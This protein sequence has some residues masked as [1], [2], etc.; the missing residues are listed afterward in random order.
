[1]TARAVDT[2]VAVLAAGQHGVV[3]RA[4][5]LAAGGT[6]RVIA[7]RLASGAWRRLAAGVYVLASHAGSWRQRLVALA[8]AAGPEAVVSHEAAAAL[9]GLD[10]YP[11]GPAVVTLSHPNHQRSLLGRIHQL[12]DVDPRDVT[13]VDGIRV[14]TVARTIVDLA[15]LGRRR[16]LAD[17][18]SDAVVAGKVRIAAVRELFR[19]LARRGKPGVRLLRALLS[20]YEP[21]AGIPESRLERR[22]LAVLAR[23]GIRRPRLGAPVPGWT[24]GSGRVDAVFDGERVIV[25]FDGRRWHTRRRDSERDRARDHAAARAGYV[26]LRFTWWDVVND[27]E[28][29][30][31][32]VRDVLKGRRR[33]AA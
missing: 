1:M 28:G 17:A 27:P 19:R 4:Q 3:S 21:G 18:M 13:V 30:C 7:T 22:G 20:E 12:T 15:A 6:D 9:H 26:V 23:G 24:P 32:I 29:T 2:A 16:R 10:G 33:A 25:E 31:A 5:V 8:L 14:T 11:P